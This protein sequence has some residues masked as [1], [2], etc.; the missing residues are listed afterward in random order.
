MR[1]R[2]CVVWM[3]VCVCVCGCVW[4]VCVCVC[5][6][7]WCCL[8]ANVKWVCVCCVWCVA[9]LDANLLWQAYRWEA[10]R[11]SKTHYHARTS[12]IGWNG[13][14]SNYGRLFNE[15][16]LIEEVLSRSPVPDL[17]SS[18]LDWHMLSFWSSSHANISITNV[19]IKM[20][21]KCEII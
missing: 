16:F 19:T 2:V 7:V 14:H 17:L 10:V 5:V 18:K 4:C 3:C 15:S 13:R 12:Y 21:I 11:V 1:V 6:C 8:C 9:W 20:H